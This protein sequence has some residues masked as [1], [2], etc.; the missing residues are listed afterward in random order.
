MVRPLPFPYLNTEIVHRFSIDCPSVVHRF[1][2]DT[3][4][5]QWRYD[6]LIKGQSKGHLW[7]FIGACETGKKLLIHN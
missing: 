5:N 1:D 4:E 6:D 2:G 3:M 7:Q